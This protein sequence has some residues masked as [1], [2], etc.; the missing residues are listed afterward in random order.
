MCVLT[1][2]FFIMSCFMLYENFYQQGNNNKNNKVEFFDYENITETVKSNFEK[3][4]K[5]LENPEIYCGNKSL[6]NSSIDNYYVSEDFNNLEEL[7]TYLENYF[8]ENLIKINYTNY[9]EENNKLYCKKIDKQ[10]NLEL[11]NQ[12]IELSSFKEDSVELIVI[13]EFINT[14]NYEENYSKYSVSLNKVNESW[15]ISS[16]SK[17]D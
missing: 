10:S 5:Y 11:E 7:K 8:D 14:D 16:Y 15:I 17:I 2:M 9:F 6:E 4:Y 1:I 12:F 13:L 3:V